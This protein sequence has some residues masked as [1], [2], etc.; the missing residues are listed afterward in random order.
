[1][2]DVLREEDPSPVGDLEPAPGLAQLPALG[3][4]V[5]MA[6][7]S[8]DFDLRGTE[9]LPDGVALSVYRIVQEALTNV[10]K[11]AAP[12]RCRVAIVAGRDDVRVDVVDDG[13]RSTG[14]VDAADAASGRGLIG[15][16]ERVRMLGGELTVG[17][18]AG[19]GFRVSALIPRT[20]A[21]SAPLAPRPS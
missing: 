15:M 17:P 4:R 3:D 7:V 8:V 18:E 12:A 9:T 16:R 20:G 14:L 21:G 10:V 13:D 5:A 11:H 6:G 19:R 1:M 2:L